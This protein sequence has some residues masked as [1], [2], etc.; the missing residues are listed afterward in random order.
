MSRPLYPLPGEEELELLP[1]AP[2]PDLVQ[3]ARLE[4]KA[5]FSNGSGAEEDHAQPGSHYWMGAI[6]LISNGRLLG[7][8]HVERSPQSPL[9]AQDIDLLEGLAGHASSALEISREKKINHWRLEQLGL[10]R[11]VSA[12]IAAVLN[13]EELCERITGLIQSTFQYYYVA[14]FTMTGDPR[15]LRFR[16]SASSSG[17]QPLDPGYTVQAGEGLIGKAAETGEQIVAPDALV[18]PGFRFIDALPETLSEAC[19]PLKTRIPFWGCWTFR[20]T[21]STA[22]TRSIF[23]S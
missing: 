1:N 23:S 2:A 8:L 11:K 9:E 7:I 10:V 6:P 16:A 12:Q 20:V 17:G 19:F 14:I 18:H 3:R 21:C 4:A 22:C 13:I 15:T 5:L